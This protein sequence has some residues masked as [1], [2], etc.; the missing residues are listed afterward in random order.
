[1]LAYSCNLLK[2]LTQFIRGQAW[3]DGFLGAFDPK[4]IVSVKVWPKL[5]I[6]TDLG[7]FYFI[8][9][10]KKKLA[11]ETVSFSSF[12]HKINVIM[13]NFKCSYFW[14]LDTNLYKCNCHPCHT[15]VCIYYKAWCW[16]ILSFQEVIQYHVF[17][18]VSHDFVTKTTK[19]WS[20]VNRCSI[21]AHAAHVDFH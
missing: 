6:N 2:N 18:A 11:G 14:L 21:E 19:P 10:S 1:M 12:I 8:T 7:K 9:D 16:T 13:D 20:S 5:P 4:F 15:T 3:G 17:C